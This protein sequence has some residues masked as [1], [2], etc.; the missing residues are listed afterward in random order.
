M[1]AWDKPAKGRVLARKSGKGSVY[2]QFVT[3]SGQV[4]STATI[5]GE[6]KQVSP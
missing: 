5:A 3:S 1:Q 2:L 4:V 6:L